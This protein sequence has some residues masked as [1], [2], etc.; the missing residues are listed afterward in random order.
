MALTGTGVTGN[1]TP[2]PSSLTFSS[3]TVGTTS[4]AQTVTLTAGGLAIQGLSIQKSG[5]FSETNNCGTSIHAAGTCQ[6]QVTFTP[7]A[8]GSRTGTITITDNAPNSPQT[9][10]LTGTGTMA[11]IGLGIASGGSASATVNAG[12]S[13]TYSLSIGGQG[14][15]GAAFPHMH[16]SAYRRELLGS[17]DSV[18]ERYKR[19]KVCRLC[20]DRLARFGGASV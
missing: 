6:L 7:T 8:T 16:G 12:T 9:I 17:G 3:Q 11:S 15:S 20:N 18:R 10:A 19:H 2:S 5:D 14:M 4:P 13:A 1:L